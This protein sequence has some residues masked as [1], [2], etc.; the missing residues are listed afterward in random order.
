MRR[1]GAREGEKRRAKV[2][3]EKSTATQAAE[4]HCDCSGQ[5]GMLA[6]PTKRRGGK[7]EGDTICASDS[8]CRIGGACTHS[9]GEE[10]SEGKGTRRE[11]R[12]LSP[13][14]L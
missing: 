8:G 9:N 14:F 4:G 3:G 6:F 7:R 1:D 10:D 2:G 11:K 13:L 5:R 12:S